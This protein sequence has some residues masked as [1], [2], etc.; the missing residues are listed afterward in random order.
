MDVDLYVVCGSFDGMGMLVIN[1]LVMDM[2]ATRAVLGSSGGMAKYSYPYADGVS[3]EFI[4][5]TENQPGRRIFLISK[6][7]KG[8]HVMFVNNQKR[9][10]KKNCDNA[11][12]RVTKKEKTSTMHEPLPCCF[13]YVWAD[14]LHLR[15]I[16]AARMLVY[17]GMFAC[18]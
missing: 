13:L 16:F 11:R 2:P 6:D 12:R 14:P 1:F 17:F 5:E 15:F 7:Y 9:I 3:L 4:H 8:A 18:C 10:R